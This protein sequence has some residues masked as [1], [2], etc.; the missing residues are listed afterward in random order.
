MDISGR[1]AVVT[2]AG[3]GIA[4]DIRVGGAAGPHEE[5]NRH[6]RTETCKNRFHLISLVELRT[7]ERL[8]L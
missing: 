8:Y 1:A 4:T 3:V 6:K 7:D 5:G 2:T